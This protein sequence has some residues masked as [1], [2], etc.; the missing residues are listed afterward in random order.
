M[1]KFDQLL[2]ALDFHDRRGKKR[3]GGMWGQA[4]LWGSRKVFAAEV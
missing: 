4:F 1:R 2:S 3:R